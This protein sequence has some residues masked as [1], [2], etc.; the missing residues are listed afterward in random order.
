MKVFDAYSEYYDLLYD[1]KNYKGETAYVDKL[2]KKY[3]QKARAILELGCGTG[4]HANLL[5]ELDYEV[6]GIDLSKTMLEKAKEKRQ[7]LDP[8][9]AAKLSF[10]EADIRSFRA[11][12]T[13]D[14]V[15]SLFHVMSYMQTNQDLEDA[16]LTAKN[17]LPQNGLFIFDCWHGPGV[18]K[19]PPVSRTKDFSGKD[20]RISRTSKPAHNPGKNT[21]EVL[22]DILIQK[23]NAKEIA[24]LR[25]IHTMRY[26]FTDEITTL[27]LRN[28]FELLKAEEWM[29]GL[30]LSENTWN[31]CY[32]CKKNQA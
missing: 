10:E 15:I 1:S 23:K 12:K 5:A 28:N 6:M 29:T 24:K 8:S 30:P 25:E 2:I 32:I 31:A 14:V 16:I 4:M 3:A 9:R 27:L 19:D 13:Y 20:I 18:L 11:G 17:A 7:N 26:L 22:F 21:V